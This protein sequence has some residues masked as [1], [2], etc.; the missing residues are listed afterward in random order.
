MLYLVDLLSSAESES[1]LR[2]TW[3]N[4]RESIRQL[5]TLRWRLGELLIGRK[6]LADGTELP[7]WQAIYDSNSVCLSL[8]LLYFPTKS[9]AREYFFTGIESGY[10]G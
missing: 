2:E 7:L 8:S 10:M 4:F 5:Y 3:I 9:H 6:R 1:E